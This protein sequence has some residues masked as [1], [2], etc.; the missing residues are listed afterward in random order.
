MKFVFQN[1]ARSVI[2]SCSMCDYLISVIFAKQ[3]QQRRKSA[4]Q[5][6]DEVRA[7]A[8]SVSKSETVSLGWHW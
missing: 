7:A 5:Q 6:Q 1:Y 3:G 2:D 8:Q 4:L